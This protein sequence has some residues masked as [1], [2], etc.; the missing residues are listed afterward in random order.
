MNPSPPVNIG[1]NVAAVIP[2]KQGRLTI[3]ERPIPTP[4][5]GEL[6]VRNEAVAANPS[7][8]KV[9]GLGAIVNKFP[10]VLGSDLAGVVVSVGYGVKR[11]Q[12]GDRVMGFALGMVQGNNDGAALQ[13]YTLLNE[14]ATSHLP[15]NLTFEQGAVLPVAMTTASVALFA[16][17]ELPMRERHVD[18]SGAILVWSG[19]SAVGVGAVQ[20]AHALGWPVYATASPKH[21][22]WLKKLGA[23]DVWDYRDPGVAEQIGQAAKTAGLRIRGAIDARSEGS[24]FDL[25]E[26][27]LIAADSSLGG[28]NSTVL[29]WPAD[30][31][32]PG[33]A[34]VRSANCFR[35]QKD[36]QDIGHWLFGHWLQESLENGSI[37]PAP[38]PRVI[39]GGLEGAQEMLDT[40]KAGCGVR[41]ERMSISPKYGSIGESRDSPHASHVDVPSS[42]AVM[43]SPHVS[44]AAGEDKASCAGTELNLSNGENCTLLGQLQDSTYHNHTAASIPEPWLSWFF[45]LFNYLQSESTPLLVRDQVAI[46]KSTDALTQFLQFDVANL[47]SLVEFWLGEGVNLPLAG[48]LIPSSI[49]AVTQLWDE[50]PSTSPTAPHLRD[51]IS[52]L[53]VSLLQNT[54]KPIDLHRNTTVDDFFSQ[55]TGDGLRWETVG[56]FITAAS[57]A[58]LDTMSFSPLYSGEEQGR[59]LVRNLTY[60][61]DSC[62]EMCISVDHLN[63]LQIVLQYENLVVHSQIDGDESYHC[64]RRMGDLSSSLFAL[65][66]HESIDK[67]ASAIP[68]FIAELRKSAF[69][70]TY[71]ADKSLAVFLGRPPRIIKAYCDFQLPSL[72][73]DPWARESLSGTS[74]SQRPSDGQDIQTEELY[75][76]G[77]GPINYTADTVAQFGLPAAG[78]ISLA[79]L[80]SSVDSGITQSSRT[81]MVQDLSVLVAEIRTGA[82]IQD[83]EPNFALFMRATQTI[84]SLL[85]S[86]IVWRSSTMEP[87]P[88]QSI[89]SVLTDGWG[90]GNNLDP[91]EFEIGF[92]ANLAEHPTLLQQDN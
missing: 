84:Q 47:M 67:H 5:Q 38:E 60:L 86:L 91:W 39:L 40:L 31:P 58:A 75:I 72:S 68:G 18:E 73:A 36:R 85:D 52:N 26:A 22:E 45:K 55:M 2:V 54:H 46:G 89:S 33:G 82:V 14:I 37:E 62:L 76:V 51:W 59:A 42:P 44:G 21:H 88:Q 28:K 66:F 87:E 78:V 69:A 53:A 49:E 43:N 34:E 20:I 56:L 81:K 27:T 48:P 80:N 90:P 57:R 65:G 12:P 61:A 25:V 3:Q 71:T 9:Q 4:S 24:S 30:K 10:A 64:W 16:D 19:A 77:K 17:L 79:L 50:M 83:G 63:D 23:T 32:K 13:T 35:F 15:G 74:D 41:G 8:W 6:L 92:W 70:R 1:A 29:P 11:F 7:D